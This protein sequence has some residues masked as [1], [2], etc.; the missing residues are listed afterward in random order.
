MLLSRLAVLLVAC[1]CFHQSAHATG[2]IGRTLLQA[3]S[4]ETVQYPVDAT[5]GLDPDGFVQ[6]YGMK[7]T[8]D[9]CDFVFTGANI[10]QAV[11]LASN[12]KINRGNPKPGREHITNIMNRAAM[13]GMTVLR[14]WAHTIVEG[15]S[16]QTASGEYDEE[17]FKGLDFINNEA[18]KRG[19]KI[20]WIFADNW[21]GVGGKESFENATGQDFFSSATRE[22]YKKHVSVLLNRVNTYNEIAYKNDA[23]IMAWNLANELRCQGCPS[24]KMQEWIEDMCNFV[25]DIDPTHLIGIGYEGFYG[26]D[27]PL[28]MH[29]PA[30]WASQE[31]QDFITNHKTWC[32]DYV[33]FHIWPDNWDL[34]T[35]EFQREF[36]EQHIKDA[37]REIKKPVV[38]EEYGKIGDQAEKI[39]YLKSA[40]DVVRKSIENGGAARGDLF[41]HWYDDNIGPGRY[42]IWYDDSSFDVIKSHAQWMSAKAG[43]CERD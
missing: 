10:W 13:S 5:T 34:E 12:G 33:G 14:M 31:G 1:M 22:I 37:E 19:L 21:Y 9:G 2:E 17:V 15:R 20:I 43:N 38:M 16:L 8:I 3:P 29:N 36:S 25:K 40:Q 7:F 41:Y 32:V 4:Y 42:G 39:K 35:A 30:D 23:T 24:S 27:S 6:T 18:R 11:E 26:P 28:K